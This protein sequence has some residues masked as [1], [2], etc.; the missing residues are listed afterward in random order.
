MICFPDSF[1]TWCEPFQAWTPAC[2]RLY[3]VVVSAS[4]TA[5][6]RRRTQ[7]YKRRPNAKPTYSGLKYLHCQLLKVCNLVNWILVSLN[8]TFDF[9]GKVISKNIILACTV[10]LNDGNFSRTFWWSKKSTLETSRWAESKPRN[11][12]ISTAPVRPLTYTYG[13]VSR[14]AFS[15]SRCL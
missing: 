14:F 3:R 1:R 4:W 6:M 12:A 13:R 10:P 2:Q 15:S 8:Q 9:V 11:T 7:R 5:Y